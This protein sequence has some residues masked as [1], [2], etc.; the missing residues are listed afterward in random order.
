MLTLSQLQTARDH[1]ILK[2]AL[3]QGG[4]TED[5]LNLLISGADE[6]QAPRK[7]SAVTVGNLSN[8]IAAAH[9]P[10]NS[11]PYANPFTATPSQI[12]AWRNYGMGSAPGP[13]P[14]NLRV[15]GFQRQA[16]YGMSSLPDDAGFDLDDMESGMGESQMLHGDHAALNTNSN[17]NERRTLFF[18]GFS[19]RTTYRDL[20]SVVKGGKLL[21]VNLRPDR[22]ASISFLEGAADFLAW[23]KKNDIYLQ[24]KRV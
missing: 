20:L 19:E 23:A 3:F 9:K 21:S 8:A 16:S 6:Q 17:N 7:D 4:I 22:T 1:D 24:S 10:Y 2:S 12:M 5:T 18:T 15:P 14:N 11:K 13:M